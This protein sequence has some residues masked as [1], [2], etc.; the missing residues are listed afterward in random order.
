MEWRKQNWQ[1]S[2]LVFISITS[3]ELIGNEK[4]ESSLEDDNHKM[5][6]YPI[7]ATKRKKNRR[8]G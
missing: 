6:E 7:P 4:R 2:L 5:T 1:G 3:K 8:K